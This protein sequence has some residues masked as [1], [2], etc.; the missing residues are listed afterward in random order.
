MPNRFSV[1]IRSNLIKSF[2]IYGLASACSKF[3]SVLLLPIYTTIFSV[4]EYGEID[5]IQSVILIITIFGILQLETSLQRYYYE[6]EGKERKKMIST[7]LWS[8]TLLSALL[9]VVFCLFAGWISVLLFHTDHFRDLLILSSF[10]ILFTNMTTI[11][12]IIIR[13]MKKPVLFAVL[14]LTQ[15]FISIG[16]TLILVLVFD[17]GISGVF[18]GQIT[19]FGIVLL[20]QLF[21]LKNEYSWQID[22][23]ILKSA[24]SFAIPQFPA[25]LGSVCNSYVNRFFMLGYLSTF[26]IGIYS[27]SLKFASIMTLIDSAFVMAW[28]PFMYDSLKS[29]QHKELFRKIFKYACLSVFSLVVIISFFA[30]DVL[31]LFIKNQDY[32]EASKYIGWLTLYQSLFILKEIIDIGPIIT[33]KTVYVTYSYLIASGFN[34]VF[35]YLSMQA[36]GLPEMVSAMVLTNII[37]LSSAWYFSHRLYPVNYNVRLFIV[38]FLVCCVLLTAFHYIELLLLQK[39]IILLVLL[40]FGWFTRK[41]WWQALSSN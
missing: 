2:L 7:I 26:A 28:Y 41:R 39:I 32:Y 16:S 19:G 30:D 14:T 38:S 12:F 24:F 11:F 18:M 21:L 25:R 9:V 13:Y 29:P 40:T 36:G 27:V 10:L 3:I 20:L 31:R 4:E 1:S 8:V 34:L 22:K 35:L 15:I 37:L 33:K 5:L 17:K 23:P 6:F